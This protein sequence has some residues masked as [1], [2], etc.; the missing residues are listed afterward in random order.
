MTTQDIAHRL[1][2]LCRQWKNKKAY[3]EL[4][5]DHAIAIEP[6][7]PYILHQRTEGKKALI[8]KNIEFVSL[9]EEFH[10]TRVSDPVIAGNYFSVSMTLDVTL[11]GQGRQHMNEICIYQ[12]EKGKIISEQ[13]FF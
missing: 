8:K 10:G 13:F 1:V 7:Y 2:D 3:E 11:K 4:Y 5:A 6:D 12:V 9:M